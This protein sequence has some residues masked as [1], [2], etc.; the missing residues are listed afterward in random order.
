MVAVAVAVADVVV[1]A[2]SHVSCLA[3]QKKGDRRYHPTTR[4]AAPFLP[5]YFPAAGD[6]VTNE[7]HMT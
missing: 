5:S 3:G 7:T 2:S 1:V 6:D 4:T